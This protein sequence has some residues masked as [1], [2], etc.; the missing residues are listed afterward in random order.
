MSE[1]ETVFSAYKI[2]G[3][4]EVLWDAFP[5]GE[6]FGGAPANF[7]C[8]SHSLGAETYVVSCIGKDKRGQMARDFLDNHGVDTSCLV[9]SDTC[10]TGVVIVTLDAEGKPDYEIKEGVAWDNIPLTDAMVALAPQLDAVCYGSLSQRN[11]VSRDTIT[12]FIA[13]T[14]PDCLRVF[15]INIR[16]HFYNDDIIRNSLQAANVL[17]LNDEELPIVA[18]LIG[19]SG[20]D[21]EIV[22][23]IIK[24][25]DLKLVALT[26]G[27]K[28]ALMATS[29]ESS[30]AAPEPTNV[31][32]TVGAGDSFTGAMIMGFLNNK[33]LAEINQAANKLAAYVC[34]QHGAVP[35]LPASLMQ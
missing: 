33:P 27:P 11:A 1:G 29:D 25:F 20:T 15:D 34:T 17:K 6:K 22:R 28:G 14:R 35:E 10:Q 31:I 23:A 2:C 3:V 12:K 21:Q 19:A 5:E 26:M 13:A 30:F 24:Q 4:G 32:N 16:Q 9:D 18:E 7:T 8:H